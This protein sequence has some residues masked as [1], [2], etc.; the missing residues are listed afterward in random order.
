MPD[1]L[2][3]LHAARLHAAESWRMFADDR[4]VPDDTRPEW[5][6]TTTEGGPLLSGRLV[7]SRPV[8]ALERFARDFHIHLT[9]PGDQRP[10]FDITQPGRTVLA[11]RHG[12]VWVEL[13]HPDTAVD[14]PKATDPADNGPVAVQAAPKSNSAPTPLPGSGRR[15]FIP[16]GRLFFTRKSRTTNPKETTPR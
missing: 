11:W 6:E 4:S 12:G 9:H 14:A 5:E 10:Y 1:T 15:R 2:N 8:W 3:A 7:G 16:G 13:W